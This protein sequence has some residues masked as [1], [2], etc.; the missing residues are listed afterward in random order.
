MRD[1]ALGTGGKWV[2]MGIPSDGSYGV[3]PGVIYSVPVTCEKGKYTRVK[4][5]TLDAFSKERM[6]KTEKELFEERAMVEHLLGP[7]KGVKA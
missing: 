7:A 2:S 1:W 5:V 4:D 3:K 6:A